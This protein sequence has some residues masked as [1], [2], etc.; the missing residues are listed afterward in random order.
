M[1]RKVT[2]LV[3]STGILLA[4]SAAVAAA[5]PG[6]DVSHII[7]QSMAESVLDVKVKE[8]EPRN[9]QGGDGHYSKCNYYS[10]PPGKTLL[11]RVYQAADGY[12]PEKE[13]ETVTKNTPAAIEVLGLGDKAIVTTGI[14]NGLPQHALML[15]AIKKNALIT[16]GLSGVE[17][18]DAALEK[19]KSVA[20]KILAQL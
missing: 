15:Y 10:V 18:E 6:I 1:T 13:F 19:A 9:V 12:D 20:Q 7:D 8:A 11:L 17:D 5:D 3:A 2:K 16:V 4:V 14:A